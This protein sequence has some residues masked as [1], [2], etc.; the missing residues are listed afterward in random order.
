M[1]RLLQDLRYGARMLATKPAFTLIAVVT[2]ALGI[3]ANTA[4]FSVVN[5]VL[6]RPLPYKDSERIMTIWQDNSRAGMKREA[7]SPANFLDIRNRNQLFEAIAAAEPFGYSLTGQGEPERFSSWLV[8]AD[9]FQILGVDALYG[10]TF[11]PEEYKS[12][13][14]AVVVIGHGLWQRRFGGDPGLVGQTVLL[15][16]QPYTIVG[17]MPPEFQFPPGRELWAPNVIPKSYSRDRGSAWIPVV[18]RLKA[19]VSVVQA[20]HEIDGIAAQLAAEYPHTNSEV[21]VR[22]VPLREQ[23]VGQVRPA[24]LVLLGAV[25]FVL[26]IA[27]TNVANLLLVRAAARHR[28]FAIRSALGANRGRLV[29]QLLTES[30]SL[31]LLGGIGGTL[32]ASW[33]VDAIIA[34][35]PGNLPRIDQIILDSHVLF[36]ALG[37]SVLTSLIFGLAPALQLSKPNLHESLKEGGRS[38]TP[39]SARHRFRN[40]L[41]VSEIGLALILLIGAGLLIRSFAGLLQVDPGFATQK[42]LTLE[43]HVWGQSRTPQQRMAFFDQTVNRIAALP[44]VEAAGAVSALPFH[45]NSI[46]IRS[47]FTIEGVP[48]PLAGEEPTAYATVATVDYFSALGI[49]LRHGRLF[50]RFD[51]QDSPPIVLIGETMARRFWPAEDP[52]GKRIKVTFMGQPK[53]R[54][55]IGVI[56]DVRHTGLDSDPRVELFLPHLQEP[57]GSMTYVVRTAAD[58]AALLPTVKEAI[59]SVN[60]DQPF[61][62]TAT[63]EALVS[64]SLAERRFTLLLLGSFAVI[65]LTM[66]AVGIYGL[67]S[68][69]T[70][71]RIHEIGVRM[72][73]GAQARD[74]FKL[75]VGEGML[76]TT[77]GVCAGLAGAFALT[78]VMSG[79]LFRVSPTD[80]ITFAAITIL[81]IVV[82]LLACYL[83]ARRAT[84]VDPMLALR[85]E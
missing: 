67:I 57:Y 49:P 33:G 85:G 56:G 84:R 2:L 75:V 11:L 43:V 78:H 70:S 32:L 28:E 51:N 60:R 72:A 64:R 18:G 42:A 53:V 16:G 21:G 7:V 58:P 44:G 3:G 29:R 26:L 47:E 8:S 34:L 38:L 66:A 54:E 22:V 27:C 79:L 61:A 12:G 31:A 52:V 23:M 35:S 10:R 9:F 13:N 36:F 39:G 82:S 19:G 63:I 30:L 71:Q 69:S 14:E 20:Q 77:L 65:A 17:V 37:V 45:T 40:V 48:A 68:F 24:L 15:N 62:S 76:L 81:L 6:L 41:V 50:T 4:I 80:P 59:W 46:D 83:P 73:L 1:Q 25:G 55:V 5:A 74:I